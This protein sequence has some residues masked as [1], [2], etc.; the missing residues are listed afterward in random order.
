M[1]WIGSVSQVKGVYEAPMNS[2]AEFETWWTK[3]S[4]CD[5]LR[6]R[7]IRRLKH[8]DQHLEETRYQIASLKRAA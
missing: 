1:H 5:K 8:R 2:A 7:W 3:I 4:T 6:D